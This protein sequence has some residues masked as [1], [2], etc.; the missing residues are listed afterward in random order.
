MKAFLP[1]S[2]KWEAERE[3]ESKR[4]CTYEHGY[5]KLIAGCFTSGDFISIGITKVNKKGK[6]FHVMNFPFFDLYGNW[7]R[8]VYTNCIW[9]VYSLLSPK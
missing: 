5:L 4:S 6:L 8:S 1:D 3:T 9:K 2:D 7:Y